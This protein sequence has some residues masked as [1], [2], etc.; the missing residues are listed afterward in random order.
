MYYNDD[1]GYARQFTAQ[2]REEFLRYKMAK[3]AAFKAKKAAAAAA[4]GAR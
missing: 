3:L 4:A 1:R 2:E